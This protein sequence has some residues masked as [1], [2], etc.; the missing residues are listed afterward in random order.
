MVSASYWGPEAIFYSTNGDPARKVPMEVR[1]AVTHSLV[2][3][4]ADPDRIEV[5][6]NPVLTD[7][8]GNLAFYIDPGTYDVMMTGSTFTF[9]IV[10]PALSSGGGGGGDGSFEFVQSI[11]Q[12]VW[13]I[14]HNLG[15]RPASVSVFSLDYSEQFDEFAVQHVNN[16]QLLVSM[17]VPTAGRALM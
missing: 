3:L 6:D 7:T 12:S 10:I 4:Y 9:R 13:S 2:A 14:T 15:Y 11:A 17:D 1:D 16:N 8:Y 5:L